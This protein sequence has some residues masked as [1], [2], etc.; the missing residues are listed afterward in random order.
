M[1]ST[2]EQIVTVRKETN[3][4]PHKHI[5]TKR[6]VWYRSEAERLQAE[7]DLQGYIELARYERLARE[8]ST[9]SQEREAKHV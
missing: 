7:K 6:S 4:P 5:V 8:H 9:S 2:R 1:G 3:R